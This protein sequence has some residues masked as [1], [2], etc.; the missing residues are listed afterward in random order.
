MSQAPQAKSLF[1]RRRTT[2]MRQR[3]SQGGA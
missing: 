1:K 3:F 2:R